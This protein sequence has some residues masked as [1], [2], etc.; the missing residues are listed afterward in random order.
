MSNQSPLR[1]GGGGTPNTLPQ[2]A[3]RYPTNKKTIYDRNLNRTKNSELSRATFA[4]LFGEMIVYAQRK[5]KGIA[6][7][8]KAYV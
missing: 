5:V 8:E 6:D 2:N 4:F 3:L 7:L 1:G